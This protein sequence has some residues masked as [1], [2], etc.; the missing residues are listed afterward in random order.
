MLT[1]FGSHK[2]STTH[3]KHILSLYLVI[4]VF[5]LTPSNDGFTLCHL[6][7]KDIDVRTL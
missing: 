7:W 3:T 1:Y 6:V 4:S 5:D 2:V